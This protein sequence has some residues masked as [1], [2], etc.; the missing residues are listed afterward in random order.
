[1]VL[2]YDFFMYKTS[3][4]CPFC[5]QIQPVVYWGT[6]ESKTRRFRCK[7]CNKTFTTEP[8]S[9]RIPL[10]KE[11]LIA[12]LLQERLSIE[13]IARVTNSAKRTVYNVLKK[14]QQT[15]ESNSNRLST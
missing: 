1:M 2:R 12:K 13:A 15:N 11:Q 3:P 6:N 10:E 4:P 14:T 7:E 9:N 5:Q 8:K